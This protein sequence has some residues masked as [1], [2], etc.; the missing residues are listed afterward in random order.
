M[1]QQKKAAKENAKGF[2]VVNG[3]KVEAVRA[4]TLRFPDGSECSIQFVLGENGVDLCSKVPDCDENG[5]PLFDEATDFVSRMYEK[6]KATP[7]D[8]ALWNAAVDVLQKDW[9]EILK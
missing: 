5:N 3:V 6:G 1:P 4:A 2:I 7:E 8:K 9:K